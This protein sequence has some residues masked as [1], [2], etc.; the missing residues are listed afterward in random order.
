M[1]ASVMAAVQRVDDQSHE[2]QKG[3]ADGDG[4]LRGRQRDP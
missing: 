1:S 2:K 4:E 3:H